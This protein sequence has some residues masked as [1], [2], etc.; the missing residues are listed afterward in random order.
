MGR[1]QFVAE[2]GID[3][4]KDS[5]TVQEFVDMCKRRYGGEIISK[6]MEG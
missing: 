1:N 5:F 3:L 4:D 6:L 2:K